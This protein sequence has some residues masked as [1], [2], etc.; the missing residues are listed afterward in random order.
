MQAAPS[1]FEDGAAWRPRI[2]DH[3]TALGYAIRLSGSI[4]D[5]TQPLRFKELDEMRYIFL[6]VIA[7]GLLT[8][9]ASIYGTGSA[10]AEH[11]QAQSFDG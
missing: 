5:A 10:R 11:A 1:L 2:T 9:V 8:S 3:A 4:R 7:M 6:S